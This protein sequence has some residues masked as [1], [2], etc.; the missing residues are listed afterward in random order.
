M[1]RIVKTDKG[2]RVDIR[3]KFLFFGYWTHFTHAAGLP[4]VPW[5]FSSYNNAINDTLWKLKRI[6]EENSD[7]E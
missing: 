6:I 5:Y 2:Y 3:K 1:F 7:L 4:N